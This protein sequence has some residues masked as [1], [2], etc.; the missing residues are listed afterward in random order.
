VLTH[1]KL[2]LL[3]RGTVQNRVA[4]REGKGT[5]LGKVMPHTANTQQG[6]LLY[7]TVAPLGPEQWWWAQG[8]SDQYSLQIPWCLSG[9]IRLFH[10]P[11]SPGLLQTGP[12]RTN[13]M[14]LSM[15]PL[16][17]HQLRCQE[18]DIRSRVHRHAHVHR[19]SWAVPLDSLTHGRP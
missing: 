12:S 7:V 17:G 15:R 4:P 1:W 13:L 9:W 3:W 19:F 6:G 11:L 14:L 16:L 8:R 5:P 18:R 10:S 2:L